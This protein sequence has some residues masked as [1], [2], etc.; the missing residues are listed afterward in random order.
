MDFEKIGAAFGSAPLFWEEVSG[1][2]SARVWTPAGG[3]TL[4]L[5]TLTDA[6]QGEKEWLITRHLRERNFVH[7]P[8]IIPTASGEPFFELDGVF[9]QLQRRID[10]TRPDPAKPGTVEKCVKLVLSLEEALADCPAID[11]K[12]RFSLREAWQQGRAGWDSLEIGV[13]LAEADAAVE[14]CAGM[15]AGAQQ[16]IHGDLGPWNMIEDADGE[17]AIIDFG[18]ARMGEPYFDV[19]SLYGGILN[20]SRDVERPAAAAEFLSAFGGDRERLYAQLRLWAWRGI[21]Q[22]AIAGAD[23]KTDAGRMVRRFLTAQERAESF[24]DLKL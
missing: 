23:G 21:A 1:G 8:D 14:Q 2:T 4:L 17:L 9:Y 6:E 10:G 18:E 13:P 11:G 12:D 7:T 19:A 5:R 15:E 20:H 22:W 3:E 16:V 24:R